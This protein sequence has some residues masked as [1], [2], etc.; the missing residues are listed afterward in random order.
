[1]TVQIAGRT[2]CVSVRFRK[3]PTGHLRIGFT[4]RFRHS[5]FPEYIV[6][7]D[8]PLGVRGG[9]LTAGY[10]YF[11]G[12]QQLNQRAVKEISLY[13][14]T[15]AFVADGGVARPPTPPLSP[16]SLTDFYWQV[17]SG[18]PTGTDLVP[19][20]SHGDYLLIRQS[21]GRAVKPDRS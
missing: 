2:V 7:L 9:G 3:K 21:D 10:R 14:S 11:R 12:G 18:A 20:Q 19:N 13:G 4:P 1:V 5:F 15:V 16:K 8:P 6:E 17:R